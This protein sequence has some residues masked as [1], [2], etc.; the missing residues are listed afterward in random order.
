MELIFMEESMP[1]RPCHFASSVARTLSCNVE[2][3]I[4]F[5]RKW[6]LRRLELSAGEIDH[7]TN[8]ILIRFTSIC[9]EFKFRAFSGARFRQSAC[10]NLGTCDQNV[11]A[12]VVRQSKT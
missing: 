7:Y 9:T 12:A 1:S 3:E 6:L 2:N 5:I 11:T 8:R 10:S 4:K